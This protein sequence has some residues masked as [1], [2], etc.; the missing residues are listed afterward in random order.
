MPSDAFVGQLIAS[1]YRLTRRLGAGGMGAVWKAHDETLDVVVALKQ[2]NLRDTQSATGQQQLLARAWREAQSTARLRGHPHIVTMHDVVQDQRMPWIVLELIDGPSLADVINR[3]GPLPADRVTQIGLAVLGA[4][5][6]A[7]ANGIVH[8]DIKPANILLTAAGTAKLA[9]FGIATLH[10]A[11]RITESGR[12]PMSILYTAPERLKNQPAS[13][14]SDLFSLGVTL[15]EAVDGASPFRRKDLPATMYAILDT[16]PPPPRHA[17]PPLAD[18]LRRMLTKDP[19]T[20]A[21]PD[22]IRAGLAALHPTKPPATPSS[23]RPL[24]ATTR[25]APPTQRREEYPRWQPLGTPLRGHKS[26]WLSRG[27]LAV[28][29]SPD[30]RTLASAG[31]DRTV[32][33]W[34]VTDLTATPHT[35]TGHTDWVSS[36]V[37]SP[38]GRTLASAGAD[39]TVRLWDV[40]D[41]TATPHTLTDHTGQVLSVAFSP[42]GR[43]LASAGTDRTVRLRD[44]TD[45]TATPHTLTGHTDGVSSVVFSPD[46]RTLASASWDRTVR[47]WDVTDLTT[48]TRTR[49][50]TLTDHTNRVLSVAFSP[51][52]RTLASASRDR[53]VRLRDV[54]DLTATPRT[55]TDHTN[56]VL[57]VAFSPD[58]RTLASAGA[59]RTVRLRDVTD[60]TT[61]TRT[62]THHTKG[63][64]SVV[65][66]PDGR[67]LASAG[68]DNTVRLWTQQ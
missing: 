53:T 47:L 49:T 2:I 63:V 31:T 46:G 28:V 43:T 24:P 42:D 19:T 45:L 60:I 8:R 15:Y 18:L 61:H 27:V 65:F 32:R 36:V 20:R 25:S 10:D 56:E 44:V 68:D 41:L 21:D 38:D 13:L 12:G 40:T 54:T 3:D 6:F 55:L 14:A 17:P 4:L 48:H 5:T 16:E 34:D 59:D 66:S 37:F 58:G 29:F 51:D 52:G 33:L 64:L 50:R 39:R 23:G 35:L 9:D 57:S 22:Q 1:R 11:T 7:D 26:F 30:G 62:L 67:T